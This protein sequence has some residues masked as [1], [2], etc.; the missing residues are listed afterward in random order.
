MSAC[1]IATIWNGERRAAGLEATRCA[2]PSDGGEPAQ[3]GHRSV[4]QEPPRLVRPL[5]AD[6]ERRR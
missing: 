1:P 6:R 3:I 2:I 4:S 5:E